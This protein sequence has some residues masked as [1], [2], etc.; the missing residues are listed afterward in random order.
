MDDGLRP[1]PTYK[2]RS[3]VGWM[4][5]PRKEVLE[6]SDRYPTRR[7]QGI[8]QASKSTTNAGAYILAKLPLH[9]HAHYL[10]PVGNPLGL[11]SRLAFEF[12]HW[13]LVGLRRLRL[14]IQPT[15]E[16]IRRLDEERSE[17][18]QR[19]RILAHAPYL[20]PCRQHDA[21]TISDRPKNLQ[22]NTMP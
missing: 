6:R 11:R 3:N 7:R 5:P 15:K 16:V 17:V 1:Y 21:V 2:R 12:K 13:L 8:R 10:R 19:F 18:I 22:S 9:A 4:M 14:L 20:L